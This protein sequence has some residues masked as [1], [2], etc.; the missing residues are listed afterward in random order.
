MGLTY[1]EIARRTVDQLVSLSDWLLRSGGD[2]KAAQDMLR[3]AEGDIRHLAKISRQ[4]VE[5]GNKQ[6]DLRDQEIQSIQ[7]QIGAIYQNEQE[8]AKKIN[9]LVGT[10]S[11]LRT[12]QQL[13]KEAIDSTLKQIERNKESLA[14]RQ[15]KLEELQ[16]WCWVPGYG[17]YL[18]GRTLVDRDVQESMRLYSSFAELE[19]KIGQNQIS[20]KNLSDEGVRLK[21]IEARHKSEK[22]EL[23]AIRERLRQSL[24]RLKEVLVFF[25]DVATF[26]GELKVLAEDDVQFSVESL[27]GKLE[28]LERKAQLPSL[29]D[30][31]YLKGLQKLNSGQQVLTIS[32]REGILR[33]AD[34]L[35]NREDWQ[36][37]TNFSSD[38]RPGAAVQHFEFVAPHQ[39]HRAIYRVDW[40]GCVEDIFA[41]WTE[42]DRLNDFRYGTS[43]FG[44]LGV[45]GGRLFLAKWGNMPMAIFDRDCA[46][47]DYWKDDRFARFFLDFL[48]LSDGRLIQFG[49]GWIEVSD[50]NNQVRGRVHHDSGISMRVRSI[51]VKN[52]LFM[53]HNGRGQ[54][55]RVD[56]RE[57]PTFEYEWCIFR[58]VS[59]LGD[60]A[61]I[62]HVNGRF[63]VS[64]G[65]SIFSFSA[66]PASEVKRLA[67]FPGG[68]IRGMAAPENGPLFLL[69]GRS[70]YEVDQSGNVARTV[71]VHD[72][73]QNAEGLML[74]A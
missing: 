46:N 34:T 14:E 26:W 69:A 50:L 10:L 11:G 48:P 7:R 52:Q 15:R 54:I 67:A 12:S 38:G 35:G 33:V 58:D 3:R 18:A 62:A 36:S 16:K 22:G 42:H 60:P 66:D 21:E 1:A 39:M 37:L 8:L 70:L 32:L 74:L 45:A 71:A 24:G 17:Q 43:G 6:Y 13:S 27:K 5:E 40:D 44:S 4:F 65:E 23:E 73:F 30:D 68:G 2:R 72:W 59:H 47:F 19:G 55:L 29:A 63:F 53:C 64:A 51:V 25:G 49:P 31:P 56:L 41:R 20:L 9:D 61:H 28:R 57:T